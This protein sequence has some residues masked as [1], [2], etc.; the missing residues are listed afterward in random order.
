M[1]C[2]RELQYLERLTVVCPICGARQCEPCS[3]RY[4]PNAHAERCVHT[5]RWRLAT[6]TARGCFALLS[7]AYLRK[8]YQRLIAQRCVLVV[9]MGYEPP[10]SYAGPRSVQP[11]A[12][13]PISEKRSSAASPGRRRRLTRREG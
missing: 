12:R 4:R 2:A 7:D 11:P 8:Q 6:P 9:S 1:I 10:V 13:N 3:V 5:G